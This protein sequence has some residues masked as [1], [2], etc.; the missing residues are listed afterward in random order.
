MNF[1]NTNQQEIIRLKSYSDTNWGNRPG[2][3][4]TNHV[5]MM[6]FTHPVSFAV[7]IQGL[8]SQSTME[9]DLVVGAL[10]VM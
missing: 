6:M 10:A 5:Y 4:K 2:N 8:T 1:S 7:G 9:T 3:S